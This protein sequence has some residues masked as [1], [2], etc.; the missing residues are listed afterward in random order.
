MAVTFPLGRSPRP[1]VQLLGPQQVGGHH[2]GCFH[3]RSAESLWRGEGRAGKD[4][5]TTPP[6][7]TQPAG[8]CPWD[9]PTGESRDAIPRPQYS[10]HWCVFISGP[11]PS[12]GLG[13]LGG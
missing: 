7:G 2:S 12:K 4:D 3:S 5:G 10:S 13:P 9:K 8:S 6:A 11:L 1:V